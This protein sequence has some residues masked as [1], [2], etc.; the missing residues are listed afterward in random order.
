MA[1]HFHLSTYFHLHILEAALKVTAARAPHVCSQ[2]IWQF[3][4]TVIFSYL[5]PAHP[6][7]KTNKKNIG[8]GINNAVVSDIN[9]SISWIKL[10]NLSFILV[11]LG[12]TLLINRFPSSSCLNANPLSKSFIHSSV[13]IPTN[14][15]SMCI[16]L[17]LDYNCVFTIPLSFLLLLLFRVIGCPEKRIINLIWLLV[18][19]AI[20]VVYHCHCLSSSFTGGGALVLLFKIRFSTPHIHSHSRIVFGS[21]Q[22]LIATTHARKRRVTSLYVT[23]KRGK[24]AMFGDTPARLLLTLDLTVSISVHIFAGHWG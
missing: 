2:V 19:V 6:P 3:T 16:N 10:I 21:S 8:T 22:L 23:R 15:H 14:L 9:H 11:C 12:V 7:K 1:K 17:S 4:L 5:L 18:V 13:K 24:H 20:V